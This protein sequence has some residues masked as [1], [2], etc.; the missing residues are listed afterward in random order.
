MTGPSMDDLRRAGMEAHLRPIQHEIDELKA[1]LPLPLRVLHSGLVR[2][3]ALTAR[4]EAA[5]ARR[6]RGMW[7]NRK[8]TL[9][10]CADECGHERSGKP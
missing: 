4:I 2:L 7:G 1:S 6:A 9:R 8:P 10:M 3:S 5:H